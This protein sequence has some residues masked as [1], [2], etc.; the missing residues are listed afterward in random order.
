M[1][2]EQYGQQGQ[3]GRIT[4]AQLRHKR[5]FKNDGNKPARKVSG[6]QK[7]LAEAK[8]SGCSISITTTAGELIYGR[9]I[10]SDKFTITVGSTG[11]TVVY[12]H[13]IESFRLIKDEATGNGQ[14][15]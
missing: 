11:E 15:S 9:L 7:M 3:R 13:A 1:N 4:G 6:H 5:P 2:G 10:D 12:K 14:P 8:E